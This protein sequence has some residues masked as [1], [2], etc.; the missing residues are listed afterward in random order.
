V[1]SRKSN[2]D[3]ASRPISPWVFVVG[4]CGF[5]VALVICGVLV[6]FF[7]RGYEHGGAGVEG[8]DVGTVGTHLM[9]MGGLAIALTLGLLWLKRSAGH[10]KRAKTKR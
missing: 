6:R 2:A 3:L 9:G 4:G 5:G 1:A 7:G 8:G 10:R